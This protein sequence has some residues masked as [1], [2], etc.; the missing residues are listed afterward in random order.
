MIFKVYTFF[1]E[2]SSEEVRA[3]I[4]FSK[5]QELTA[6]AC[7]VS[8]STVAR[9]LK[10]ENYQLQNLMYL[11]LNPLVNTVGSKNKLFSNQ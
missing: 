5:C 6:R 4:E 2:L 7:N 11:Y 9:I 10:Q 8:V 1:N 3:K